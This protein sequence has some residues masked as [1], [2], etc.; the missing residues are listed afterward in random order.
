MKRTDEKGK[1]NGCSV[2]EYAAYLGCGSL[3]P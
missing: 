3:A 2:G 1:G